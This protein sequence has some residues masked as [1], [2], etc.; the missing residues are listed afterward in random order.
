MVWF[1]LVNNP[2]I[3]LNLSYYFSSATDLT[4][5]GLK[6]SLIQRA[7]QKIF[8]KKD[9]YPNCLFLANYLNT[10]AQQPM[11]FVPSLRLYRY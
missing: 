4:D 8:I 5:I 2:A 7:I 9:S 3:W 10:I 11:V 1:F 6:N